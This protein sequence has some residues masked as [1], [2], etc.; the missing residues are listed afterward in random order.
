MLCLY[1]LL[2]VYVKSQMSS[3]LY[4]DLVAFHKGL[5]VHCMYISSRVAFDNAPLA[6]GEKLGCLLDTHTCRSLVLVLF[7]LQVE[8]CKN[9]VY[10]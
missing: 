10:R 5:T 9:V 7:V 3:T 1:D 6:A 4:S 2:R 8:H